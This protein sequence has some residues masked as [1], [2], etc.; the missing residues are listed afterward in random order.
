MDRDEIERQL[1]DLLREE[2]DREIVAEI[3]VTA[4][5]SQGWTLVTFS[6]D[7]DLG[8]IDLWMQDNIRNDWR[9]FHGKAVFI[10]PEEAMLFRMRWS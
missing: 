8:G 7:S 10:D 4:L 2:I 9:L 6:D 1:S 3:S 5:V